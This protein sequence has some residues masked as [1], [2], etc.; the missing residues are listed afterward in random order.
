MTEI[1]QII[2]ILNGSQLT[3]NIYNLSAFTWYAVTVTAFTSVGAGPES[4]ATLIQSGIG[5]M[6][7]NIIVI[8]PCFFLI[9][10]CL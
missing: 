10:L 3:T 4:N 1:I 2:Q 9:L 5:G 8:I 7:A 6:S